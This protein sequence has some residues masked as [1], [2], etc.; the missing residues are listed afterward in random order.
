[1][2]TTLNNSVAADSIS[3]LADGAL[4]GEAFAQA[5]A[6]CEGDP[7]LL[8]RWDDYHLIGDVL[9]SPDLLA[10]RTSSV[11]LT[12]LQSRLAQE[13]IQPVA[14][15]DTLPTPSSP[16]FV[17]TQAAANDSVFRWKM[18]AGVASMAAVAVMIWTVAVPTASTGSQLA[19]NPSSAD[20]VLVS[21]PQG[22]IVRDVRLD[23]FLAA[24][25]QVGGSSALQMPSGF[26]RNAT[27]ETSPHARR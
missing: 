19:L 24:H 6:A 8:A 2:K 16:L 25:K 12:R 18:V 11:F 22:V 23:E 9:R 13:E 10:M 27:F 3:A 1:M 26:L 17:V 7:A 14:Q 4:R 5:L 15:T 21:S 20:S